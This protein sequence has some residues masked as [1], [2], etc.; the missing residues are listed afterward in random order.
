[1]DLIVGR[2]APCLPG[3]RRGGRPLSPGGPYGCME[4]PRDCGWQE[5][6]SSLRRDQDGGGR[7]TRL[8]RERIVRLH[9]ALV[10]ARPSPEC[11]ESRSPVI[12][13]QTPSRYD[14]RFFDR[15]GANNGSADFAAS[16]RLKRASCRVRPR[17]KL[18][19]ERSAP[20]FPWVQQIGEMTTPGRFWRNGLASACR[21]GRQSA[22]CE[23]SSRDG[24]LASDNQKLVLARRRTSWT[25]RKN[26]RRRIGSGASHRRNTPRLRS[27]HSG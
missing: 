12:C 26:A 1:M 16:D 7:W 6:P 20:A 13:V 23:S 10:K 8:E 11:R 14:L 18:R 17:R 15:F 25:R 21:G 4:A 27:T 19:V 9:S 22:R 5:L 3:T 24:T 2:K